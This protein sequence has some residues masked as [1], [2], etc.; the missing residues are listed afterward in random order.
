MPL[1]PVGGLMGLIAYGAQDVYLTGSPQITFFRTQYRRHTTFAMET[2]NQVFNPT[3]VTEQMTAPNITHETHTE[4]D[5]NIINRTVRSFVREPITNSDIPTVLTMENATTV[6]DWVK[7]EFVN[8]DYDC[9]M[10]RSHLYDNN[11]TITVVPDDGVYECPICFEQKPLYLKFTNTSDPRICGHMFCF[12]CIK[13][14]L[15]SRDHP[16]HQRGD[17][18]LD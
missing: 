12:D 10:C 16:H 1:P 9:P 15:D 2:F 3:T 11:I 13:S 17:D 4:E 14:N 5:P 18:E 6:I 7:A 8:H